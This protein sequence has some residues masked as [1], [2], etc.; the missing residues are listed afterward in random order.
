MNPVSESLKKLM[1]YFTVGIEV[2][3]HTPSHSKGWTLHQS[4]WNGNRVQQIDIELG[5]PETNMPIIKHRLLIEQ[6]W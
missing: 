3:L 2:F 5:C 1:K 4:F 6:E